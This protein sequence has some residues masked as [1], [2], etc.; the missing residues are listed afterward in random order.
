MQR[1]SGGPSASSPPP[2]G[3]DP[4]RVRLVALAG[5]VAFVLALPL[6]VASAGSVGDDDSTAVR[7]TVRADD[8]P[9]APEPG[10]S[11]RL[12]GLG[13]ATAARCGPELSSPDGVEAQT[14]VMAQGEE[15]WARTYYRNATGDALSSVL[16]LMGPGGRTVQMNCAVDADDDP[17]VCETPRERTAGAAGAY[18]AVAEFAK[19]T[20]SAGPLLLRSGSNSAQ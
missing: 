9:P 3:P 19:G 2:G 1:H 16:S 13:L 8:R 17:G 7:E 10:R 11:P 20:G 5:V 12:L 15:T 6:A 18:T 4:R 14:C